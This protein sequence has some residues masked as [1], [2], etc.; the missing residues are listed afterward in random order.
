MKRITMLSTV[1]FLLTG[2]HPLFAQSPSTAPASKFYLKAGGGYFFSVFPGQFPDVGPYPP[3]DIRQ[4]YNPANGETTTISDKVLT[5]SYGAGARGGIAFGWNIN[6][7]IA[8]EGAI[9]YYHSKENL[10]TR[11]VTTVEG[12]GQEAGSIE[13]RGYANAF[14]FAP[15]IVIN[16]GFEKINPYV[17]FGMVIPFWGRLHIE[18]TANTNTPV[19]ASAVAQTAIH[20]EE[21]VHPNIT[22]GFQGALGVVIPVGRRLDIY[23]ETEYRNVPAESKKKEV[24]SYDENTQVINTSNGQVISTQHRGLEDL[25]TA[26]RHTDYVTTL[27][28][29]SNTPVGQEG[30]QTEYKD[31]NRPSNDLKSYINIGGLGVTAGIRFRL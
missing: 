28:Q 9:N 27:D 4:S 31:N 24:T 17:R 20:R 8:L 15:G 22:L 25:S 5:G 16:P 21:E 19:S 18:T 1:I 23:V 30:A 3:H 11:Q 13:S 14:D 12:T 7:Y 6:R 2:L 29:N 10:M 26:E